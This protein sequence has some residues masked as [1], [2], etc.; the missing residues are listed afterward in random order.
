MSPS[1]TAAPQIP[2]KHDGF[3]DCLT[4]IPDNRRKVNRMFIWSSVAEALKGT[5]SMRIWFQKRLQYAREKSSITESG[6]G[7]LK[8]SDG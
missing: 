3:S 2:L 5:V 8:E 6:E 7:L 4:R 1:L